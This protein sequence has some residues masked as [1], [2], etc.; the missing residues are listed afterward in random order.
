M[1]VNRLARF[2]WLSC[3]VKQS[4]E[5]HIM[6]ATMRYKQQRCAANKKMRCRQKKMRCKQRTNAANKNMPCIMASTIEECVAVVS[7]VAMKAKIFEYFECSSLQVTMTTRD[8]LQTKK[9]RCKQK[10][11]R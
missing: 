4:V 3:A 8:T 6:N 9:M 11:E 1:S 5:V 10:N 7:S 2:S